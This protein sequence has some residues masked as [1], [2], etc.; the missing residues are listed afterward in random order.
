M[1]L[2]HRN[3]PIGIFDSGV[4][5]LSV[6]KAIEN[7]LPN[8]S[9]IYVAD[10]AYAPYG[11][12]SS[13]YINDRSFALAEYFKEKQVKAIVVA[14]N[15]ASVVA[16]N[17][18]RSRLDVPVVGIE[19]AIKP[20]ARDTRS[21][22]IGVLATSRTVESPNVRKLCELYGQDVEIILQ[23]CPGLVEQIERAQ[24]HT[25]STQDMLKAFLTPLVEAGADTIVLGCTHYRFVS[26]QIKKCIG[27][28]VLIMEPGAAVARQLKRKLVS[29]STMREDNRLPI[30]P[31]STT[32]YTTGCVQ[33]SQAVFSALIGHD[34]PLHPL[35]LN[36][37]AVCG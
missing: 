5:G 28:D 14:C 32:F 29:A 26:E 20:A 37:A 3:S 30:E 24:Q 34:V 11:E 22:V 35:Q 33:E 19:P 21:G 18:L 23:A 9:L 4:G 16:L 12:R 13:E 2:E 15:T 25:Q 36:E 10:S 17:A 27:D 7:H 1:F 6:L 31:Y 8:E